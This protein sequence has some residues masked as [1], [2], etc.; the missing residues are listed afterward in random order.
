[1]EI[2]ILIKII[3]ILV[4]I[5]MVIEITAYLAGICL[6]VIGFLLSLIIGIFKS[7]YEFVKSKIRNKPE[8]YGNYTW[9]RECKHCEFIDE[10]LE[11]K[12]RR[13]HGTIFK[14]T[15]EAVPPYIKVKSKENIK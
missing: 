11:I 15:D 9:S 6:L 7:I 5:W 4:A 2:D 8:C 3:G 1:M 10:C 12:N 14:Y 13:I